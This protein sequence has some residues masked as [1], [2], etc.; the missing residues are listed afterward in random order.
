VEVVAN[1]YSETSN[2]IS[3]ADKDFASPP[4]PPS[5]QLSDSNGSSGGEASNRIATL[6]PPSPPIALL[7]GDRARNK[8][9]EEEGVVTTWSKN[10]TKAVIQFDNGDLSDWMSSSDL[11]IVQRLC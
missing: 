8:Q 3:G 6:S 5:P 11:L 4:S 2:L 7:V 1:D 9:T 10:R